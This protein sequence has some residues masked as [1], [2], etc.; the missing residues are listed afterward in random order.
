MT[1]APCHKTRNRSF[2]QP[3]AQ[4]S[5]ANRAAIKTCEHCPILKECAAAALT[6]GN[7]LN[8]GYSG[9]AQGVIQ[10]GVICRGDIATAMELSMIA[11]VPMPDYA[12]ETRAR[13]STQCINC[14]KPMVPWTR[15]EVPEGYV[16][17]RGRNYCTECRAAYDE[18]LI[19]ERRSRGLIK[20]TDR[21]RHHKLTDHSGGDIYIDDNQLTLFG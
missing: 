6:S 8:P 18:A 11:G 15:G 5:P 4:D 9:P 21:K 7:T 1:T 17:H 14:E 16:M 2:I 19:K 13:A 10:A 20:D 3:T 12:A